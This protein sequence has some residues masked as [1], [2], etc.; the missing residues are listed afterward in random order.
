MIRLEEKAD[1]EVRDAADGASIFYLRFSIIFYLRFS[2]C[3]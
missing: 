3:H 1:S 2:I